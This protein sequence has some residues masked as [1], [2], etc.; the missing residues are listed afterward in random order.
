LIAADAQ[1]W[2]V[3]ETQMNALLPAA[4][5]IIG[6]AFAAYDPIPFS[7]QYAEFVNYATAQ[8]QKRIERVEHA[9]GAPRDEIERVAREAID[10]EDA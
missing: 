10:A 9:R 5:G 4:L 3:I 8:F 6:D 2:R 1:V 7:L